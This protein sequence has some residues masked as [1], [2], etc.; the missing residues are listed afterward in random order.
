MILIKAGLLFRK[1]YRTVGRTNRSVYWTLLAV[2]QA[3]LTGKG[4]IGKYFKMAVLG[5][6]I[7]LLRVSQMFSRPKSDP[8]DSKW[9]SEDCVQLIAAGCVLGDLTEKELVEQASNLI[10]FGTLK[11]F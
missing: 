4:L 6:S 11:Y 9:S 2:S 1:M 3:Y 5:I 10:G 7:I 8:R